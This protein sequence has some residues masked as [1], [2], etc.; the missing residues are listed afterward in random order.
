MCFVYPCGKESKQE[1]L[2]EPDTEHPQHA[3][4]CVTEASMRCLLAVSVFSVTSLRKQFVRMLKAKNVTSWKSWGFSVS[5]EQATRDGLRPTVYV[6]SINSYVTLV[7][8][9]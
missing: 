1:Q 9:K 3:G 5:T 2:P 7:T 6:K 8:A 4:R